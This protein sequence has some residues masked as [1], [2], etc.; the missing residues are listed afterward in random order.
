MPG[1][2]RTANFAEWYAVLLV[3]AHNLKRP[4][5]VWTDSEDAVRRF[6]ALDEAAVAGADPDADPIG[7]ALTRLV[8]VCPR[9]RCGR[10]SPGR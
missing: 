7:A 10:R 5:T 3:I 9:R 2:L 8:G 4:V 1:L 6:H